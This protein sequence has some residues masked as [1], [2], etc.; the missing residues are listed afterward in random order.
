MGQRNNFDGR[1]LPATSAGA[2][3]Q[4]RLWSGHRHGAD[5]EISASAGRRYSR[6]WHALPVRPARAGAKSAYYGLPSDDRNKTDVE[7]VTGKVEHKFNDIFTD[8]RHGALW[9]LL[10][11]CARRPTPIYGTANCYTYRRPIRRRAALRR[12]A[13]KPCRPPRFNPLF[14]VA[15]TPLSQIFVAARPAQLRGHHRHPDE[16]D[17]PHGRLHGCRHSQSSHHWR[18]AGQGRC[19]RFARF[20]NQ[21]TVIVPTPL[22]TPNPYEAFP[23]RQTTITSRPVTKTATVGV[24]AVDNIDIRTA[25]ERGGGG[26]ASIISARAY[27]QPLGSKPV[28]FHPQRQYRQPARGPGLQADRQ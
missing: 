26:R 1:P 5:A 25:M 21:N 10:V 7:V 22:L 4:L 27:D 23:G 9:Q 2:S 18:A 16:R 28:A 20:A 15:G 13:A 14:P 17:R 12:P 6:Q 3:R 8:Q 11:R 24:Y 19:R